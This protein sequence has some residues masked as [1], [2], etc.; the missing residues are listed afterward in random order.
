MQKYT[1]GV[2]K[3]SGYIQRFVRG[4]EVSQGFLYAYNGQWN[5]EEYPDITRKDCRPIHKDVVNFFIADGGY[6]NEGL[7]Q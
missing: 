7:I 1:Y 6:N 4:N 5:D 3:K 2:H